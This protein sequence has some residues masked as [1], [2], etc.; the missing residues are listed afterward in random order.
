MWHTAVSL[1]NKHV[2]WVHTSSLCN[3]SSQLPQQMNAASYTTCLSEKYESCTGGY[4][5]RPSLASGANLLM[6]CLLATALKYPLLELLLLP[7]AGTALDQNKPKAKLAIVNTPLLNVQGVFIK[8]LKC[9][10]IVNLSYAHR[11][12]SS[13]CLQ[14][15]CSF[16]LLSLS[17]MQ[18]LTEPV[19]V[20]RFCIQTPGMHSPLEFCGIS[21]YY[22]PHVNHRKCE[23][24]RIMC[25]SSECSERSLPGPQGGETQASFSW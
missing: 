5:Q 3:V 16:A 6:Q 10:Y 2:N 8:R 25:R 14:T 17:S 12:M 15:L 13:C 1:R 23:A 4:L 24:Q 21:K 11:L 9:R 18:V 7:S 20:S 22:K 19:C